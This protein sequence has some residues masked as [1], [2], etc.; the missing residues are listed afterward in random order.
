MKFFEYVCQ[1]WVSGGQFAQGSDQILQ[2]IVFFDLSHRLGYSSV[3][4]RFFF[5]SGLPLQRFQGLVFCFANNS[6]SV[7]ISKSD[8][9]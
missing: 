2:T 3:N 8:D 5:R 9:T 6:A 7:P 4:Y 1:R